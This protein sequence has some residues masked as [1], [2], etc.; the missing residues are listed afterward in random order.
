MKISIAEPVSQLRHIKI[1]DNGE[2]LV[3]FLEQC[4]DLILD[5]PRFIYRRETMARKSVS[6]KLCQANVWLMEQGFRLAIVEGWRPPH[7]QKRM[8]L[9]TWGRFKERHPDWSDVTLRR[10]VNRYTAPIHGKVPPPHSTGAAVDL[11][12][13]DLNGKVQD[14]WSPYQWRDPTCFQF[15]APGLTEQARKTRQLLWDA[16]TPTG[17][18]NYPSEYWHW[19]YGDQGWAYRGGYPNA[20]YGPITPPN[21]QP[22]PADVI[23]TPLVLLDLEQDRIALKR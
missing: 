16:I 1:I 14:H 3:N 23:D 13:A 4:P 19:S 7:I 20:I 18:T 17:M 6:E 12:L 8:Y 9:G 2:P 15:D 11:V 22:E 5:H 10:V 21:Y